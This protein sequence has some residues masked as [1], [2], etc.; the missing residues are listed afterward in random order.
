MRVLFVTATNTHIGKTHT[1][2]KLIEL[3]AQKGIDTLT[4]KPIETGVESTPLDASAIL[5]TTHNSFEKFKDMT[6]EDICP[7]RY[8]LPAAPY[9]AKGEDSIDWEL[10]DESIMR[11]KKR[12]EVL[13]IEGAGGLMV[14]IDEQTMMIDMAKKYADHTLLVAPSRL[15]SINDTL[16]S[17]KALKE[18]QIKHSWMV[19]IYEDKQSFKTITAPY[20]EKAMGG[21]M[22]VQEDLEHFVEQFLLR[23]E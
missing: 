7:I 14:P 12:C 9:V 5:K 10:L 18:A 19:N 17:L 4:I 1:T 13:I 3:L 15:G 11:L 2:L 21:Y 8:A 22:S 16:L 23:K 6:L 20:Y